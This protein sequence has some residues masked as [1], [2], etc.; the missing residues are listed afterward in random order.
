M[1][2]AKPIP[3]IAFPST[4]ALPFSL[5]CAFWQ[6]SCKKLPAVCDE[7]VVG[8]R[9]SGS[10]FSSGLFTALLHCDEFSRAFILH[11]RWNFV[12]SPVFSSLASHELDEPRLANQ[13]TV[14]NT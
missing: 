4:C 12:P 6:K 7:A 10:C 5:L 1:G 8:V 14:V 11:R 9:S 3:R 2:L 13:I